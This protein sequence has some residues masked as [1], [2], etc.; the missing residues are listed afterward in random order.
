MIIMFFLPLERFSY[1]LFL[2]CFFGDFRYYYL[3]QALSDDAAIRILIICQPG[4]GDAEIISRFEC[5]LLNKR[6][7]NSSPDER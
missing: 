7:S 4:A 2:G 6:A 3:L 5:M 1:Y